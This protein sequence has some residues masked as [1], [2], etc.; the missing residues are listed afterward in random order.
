MPASFR[1]SLLVRPGPADMHF[2]NLDRANID[3]R[4]GRDHQPPPQ[5]P[6]GA[7]DG[8]NETIIV[9]TA[10]TPSAAVRA[11]HQSHLVRRVRLSGS[12]NKGG[13]MSTTDH[14]ATWPPKRS[15]PCLSHGRPKEWSSVV[16]GGPVQVGCHATANRP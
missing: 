7:T 16:R 9:T 12:F 1:S 3:L 11:P 8:T 6:A 13:P 14:L 2:H 4:K 15:G 10:A 5:P